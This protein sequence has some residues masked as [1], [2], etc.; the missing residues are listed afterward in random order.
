M[1]L[2]AL[3][4]AVL[5]SFASV[6]HAFEAINRLQVVPLG[7]Q[8]FEVIEARGDGARGMWCAAADYAITRQNIR[9][10]QRL[11]VKSPRG[12]SVSGAG[13]IG[14]VFTTDVNA[15][16]VAPSQSYSVSV[17]VAGQGLPLHHAYQFCKGYILEIDDIFYRL[18]KN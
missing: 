14:V 11:Y 13:R 17:R 18:E 7:A 3:T 6:G 1:R 10:D 12:P 8:G 9:C 15:L 2:P 4:F 16:S 5:L